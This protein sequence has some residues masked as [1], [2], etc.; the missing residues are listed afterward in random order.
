M[1][2]KYEE[3]KFNCINCR[4]TENIY[5]I[6]QKNEHHEIIGLIFVCENCIDI[7]TGREMKISFGDDLYKPENEE[8]VIEV[9]EY[10]YT[11]NEVWN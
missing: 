11:G 8:T 10:Q 5:T 9:S 6:E 7:M 3:T 4:S 1:D 2:E